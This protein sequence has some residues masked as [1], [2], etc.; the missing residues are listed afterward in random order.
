MIQYKWG[1]IN[2]KGEI[3]IPIIYDKVLS[4]KGGVALV[5]KGNECLYIDKYGNEL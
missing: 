4:F 2:R 1:F 3:V 5:E